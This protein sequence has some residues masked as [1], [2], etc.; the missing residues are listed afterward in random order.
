MRVS[1]VL[2]SLRCRQEVRPPIVLRSHSSFTYCTT[3]CLEPSLHHSLLAL[4]PAVLLLSPSRSHHLITFRR[5]VGCLCCRRC[6]GA[7][8]PCIRFVRYPESHRGTQQRPKASRGKLWARMV[9]AAACPDAEIPS[10]HA[11]SHP[12]ML[13]KLWAPAL[14]AGEQHQPV[15]YEWLQCSGWC[16]AAELYESRA[17]CEGGGGGRRHRR[18]EAG[19]PEPAALPSA[20]SIGF[21]VARPC[22]RCIPSAWCAE[23]HTPVRPPASHLGV[24]P[25]ALPA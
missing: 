23:G 16:P 15:R 13:Q 11:Q 8:P 12:G 21:G 24:E 1:T 9:L 2:C 10:A 17:S 18:R 20:R 14:P 25:G 22:S 7:A 4:Q 19:A 3:G 5:P 6:P